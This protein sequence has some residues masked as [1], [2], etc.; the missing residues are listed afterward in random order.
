LPIT[1]YQQKM[2]ED[3]VVKKVEGGE[4]AGEALAKARQRKRLTLED[5]AR[6]LKIQRRYLRD[7]ESAHYDV[8]PAEVHTIGFI[9]SYAR[10]LDLDEKNVVD[11][12][13]KELSIIKNLAGKKSKSKPAK[14]YS[15]TAVIV[16][17]RFIKIGAI[18][19][20][21]LGLFGYLWYQ[22]S[23]LSVAPKLIISQPAQDTTV[24]DSQIE[25]VGETKP[26][27]NITIN[28]QSVYVDSEGVF[29]ETVSLQE[30]LNMV[31]I[32]ATNKLDRKSV[33]ER[34]VIMEK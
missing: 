22:I 5:A 28:E 24:S 13:K 7:I 8:L 30:G 33:V 15:N 31:E 29:R 16:T 11:L 34:K 21:I 23:G 4:S 32:V 19:L 2:S 6:D 10:Y 12:Y 20:L 1:R 27:A 3:F 26:G 9:R 17:P 18:I 25:I 14:T